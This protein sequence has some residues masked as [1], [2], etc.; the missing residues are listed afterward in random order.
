MKV[1]VEEWRQ[2]GTD[3]VVAFAGVEEVIGIAWIQKV[4]NFVLV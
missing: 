4:L 3:E 2:I 1:A